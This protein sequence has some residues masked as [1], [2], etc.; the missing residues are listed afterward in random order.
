MNATDGMMVLLH[1]RAAVPIAIGGADLIGTDRIGTD[2]IETNPIETVR[3][4]C[5]DSATTLP[6]MAKAVLARLRQRGWAGEWTLV[7]LGDR[8]GA[9]VQALALEM[10][11]CD[12]PV[13]S[14]AAVPD[15]ALPAWAPQA[16]ELAAAE[17]LR[18]ACE[19][20][21]APE[22]ALLPTQRCLPH[23][24]DI[25]TWVAAA[26]AAPRLRPPPPATQS[27]PLKNGG[28]LRAPVFCIPGAGASVVSLLDLAQA[29]HPQAS[30]FGMQPRGLDGIA[31]PCTTVETAAASILAQALQAAP[32]GPIRLVG[33][34]FGGWIAFAVALMLRRLGRTVAS[35][36]L[37][38]S[39]PPTADPAMAECDE[40]DVLVRWVELVQLSSERPLG[41]DA[42][43]LR[44][45]SASARMQLVHR[46]M[47]EVGL[48]PAQS[49]PASM[50]GAL[51]MFAA[52]LRTS[53]QP[54]GVYDGV[55]RVVHMPDPEL[56]AEGNDR[57]A[58]QMHAGW[59]RHAPRVQLIR[60]GGNHMT[61]IRGRHA[62]ALAER[63]GLGD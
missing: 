55:L 9:L 44:P 5:E 29:A 31:P 34:S 48:M 51:R 3:V 42:A 30:M 53:Y 24:R 26:A 25:A 46:R 52:C 50:L 58:L 62:H 14:V 17:R 23:E 47:A 43:G 13:R 19:A 8:P 59:L 15:A 56:D 10:L 28:P 35:V 39:R 11:G 18:A 57:E 41:I 27:I 4:P 49:D 21:T 40:L 22:P 61:G 32:Q 33:H 12:L 54:A 36:D 7:G 37:L 6:G 20:W 1:E 16:Q 60:G 63:L 38:D 2:R 45:L